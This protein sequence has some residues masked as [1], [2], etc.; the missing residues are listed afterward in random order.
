MNKEHHNKQNEFFIELDEQ[1]QI[2]WN[3]LS[4]LLLLSYSYEHL[5]TEKEHDRIDMN[6]Y[7]TI[8]YDSFSIPCYTIQKQCS[9][10]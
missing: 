9:K 2:L 10:I 8:D 6:L 4:K 1:E 5:L 7:Y 3:K